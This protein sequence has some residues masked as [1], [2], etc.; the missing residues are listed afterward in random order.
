M[1]TIHTIN[2]NLTVAI[3]QLNIASDTP[4][5]D[6]EV[7][8]A[9]ALNV[10]R[11]QLLTRGD[12]ILSSIE[13]ACFQQLLNRRLMGEPIAYIVGQREFW[14]LT[15]A[16]TPATL[17]PRP[18]TELLVE[19]ALQKFSKE[20]TIKAADLG[21]GSG[22]IALAIAHERPDWQLVATDNRAAALALAKRNAAALQIGNVEF[23]LSDWFE[24]LGG[25]LF[26]LIISNPPYIA[27]DDRHL[28]QGDVRFEP[29]SALVSGADGLQDLRKMAR[30]SWAYL[31]PGGWLLLEHGFEQAQ[32]VRKLLVEAGYVEVASKCDLSGKERV[33]IGRKS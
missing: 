20:V 24:A 25:K 9:H 8:L 33:T 19:L 27:A 7:L 18:E 31:L 29:I 23:I 30:Q 32:F 22:A 10:T 3:Q 26:D 21:T 16:V 6:A 5:L 12:K 1:N 2:D 11:T 14:S 17:V 4:R 28:M 15:F 13:Q